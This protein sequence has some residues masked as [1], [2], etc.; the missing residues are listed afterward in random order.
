ML[1][2]FSLQSYECIHWYAESANCPSW[3]TSCVG[4]CAQK[5][6]VNTVSGLSITNNHKKLSMLEW[7]WIHFKVSLQWGYMPSH[8]HYEPVLCTLWLIALW[9]WFLSIG[10]GIHHKPTHSPTTPHSF[11]PSLPNLGQLPG[12]VIGKELFLL[13][14]VHSQRLLLLLEGVNLL[15]ESVGDKLLL[16]L[17]LGLLSNKE[18]KHGG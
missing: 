10:K 2:G 17:S 16:L 18:E 5:A 4:R 9:R 1:S 11:P 14:I 6:P 8:V 15:E 3:V 7:K 12:Q 13:L